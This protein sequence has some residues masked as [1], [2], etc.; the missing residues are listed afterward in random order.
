MGSV[1]GSASSYPCSASYYPPPQS[2][3]PTELATAPKK[4]SKANPVRKKQSRLMQRKQE[5]SEGKKKVEEIKKTRFQGITLLR[6]QSTGLERPCL[7]PLSFGEQVNIVWT[8]TT[9][10]Y[11]IPINSRIS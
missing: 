2:P 6:I 10:T 8:C 3:V 4:P 11:T 5:I 9:T 1:S 7:V